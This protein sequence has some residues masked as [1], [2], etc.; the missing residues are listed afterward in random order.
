MNSQP[1]PTPEWAAFLDP[2]EDDP[3]LDE[4]DRL[5]LARARATLGEEITWQSVPEGIES[6][7][8]AQVQRESSAASTV[9]AQ[10]DSDPA[11]VAE[12]ARRRHRR[13]ERARGSAVRRWLPAGIAVAASVAAVVLSLTQPWAPD[14]P[15]GPKEY[16]SMVG[17][18]L[19]PKAH[20]EVEI[21]TLQ[22][23]DAITLTIT[24]LPPAPA[25][26]YYAAWVSGPDGTVPVGSFHWRKGGIP[27]ELWSGV[28]TQEYPTLTIT[29]QPDGDP[30]RTNRVMMTGSLQP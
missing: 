8:M 17:T 28:D 30:E 20:S 15:Q 14:E 21:E 11:P 7:I 23:G 25:G 22:A 10:P 5:L 3:T 2:G 1:D 4:A 24:G 13:D 26:H 16:Y 27:I 29:V 6:R 12:L 9:A 18:A 19:S